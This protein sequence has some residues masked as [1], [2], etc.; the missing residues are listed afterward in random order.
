MMTYDNVYVAQC[1]MGANPN[2]L[3]KAIKEAEEHKG[4]SIVI[5]Y[6][7]CITHGIKIGM[8]NAQEEMKAAVDSGYW[9][10]YRWNPEDKVLQL[11]SKEPSK[12]LVEFL[13]GEIRYSA[14]DITF[15]ENAKK[16]FAEAKI[17]AEERY[18]YYKKLAEQK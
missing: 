10:L 11:D 3:M 5:C 15:P 9:N 16:L 1:A 4:P 6:A 7:P 14:L 17:S 8:N 13:R 2:Q 12:D 18:N